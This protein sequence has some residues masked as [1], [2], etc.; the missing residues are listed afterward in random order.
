MKTGKPNNIDSYIAGFPAD[1]GKRLEE[2]RAVIAQ[3]APGAGETISYQMPT[4][5]LH[6]NLVHFAGYRNHIG[7]YPA[8]SGIS[9]FAQELEGYVFAKG[10]VQFP[11]H[12][13]L[14][15]DLIARIVQFR[16]AEQNSRKKA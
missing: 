1:I 16:V 9:A 14:P 6:G 2:M 4:F 7:F 13:P 3:N 5:R 8:P 15:L 10:S 11:H 12:R